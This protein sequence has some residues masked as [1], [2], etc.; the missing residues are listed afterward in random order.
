MEGSLGWKKACVG[1]PPAPTLG[2]CGMQLVWGCE[3]V[4][5][6]RGGK[7]TPSA[8]QGC[9]AWLLSL[10]ALEADQ[11]LSKTLRDLR[12]GGDVI[13]TCM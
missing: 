2:P 7:Q 13:C 1:H 9:A 8:W 12:L 11:N 3:R 4:P 5:G 6:V 10:Q